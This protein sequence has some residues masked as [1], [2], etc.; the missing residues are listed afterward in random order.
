MPPT[1]QYI[2]QARKILGHRQ[3]RPEIDRFRSTGAQ[4]KH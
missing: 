2:A 4:I 1:P 3:A